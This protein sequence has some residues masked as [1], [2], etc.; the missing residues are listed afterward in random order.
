[1]ALRRWTGP[2][3]CALAL[4]AAGV[5]GAHTEVAATRPADGAALGAAPRQVVVVYGAPL[6]AAGEASAEVDGRDV[7]AAPPRLA[8]SDA[9]RLVLPLEPG[10]GA[11]RYV[12]RW[13]V[14]GADGHEVA[15]ELSFRVRARPLTADLHALAALLQ[16]TAERL[17]ASLPP[18]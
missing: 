1:L 5:A 11:G 13:T 16:R 12:V 9:G 14:T 7:L 17:T 2:L 8:P 3:A 4:A 6:G 18:V 15:G 10:S